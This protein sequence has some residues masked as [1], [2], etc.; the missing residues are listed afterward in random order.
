M[1]ILRRWRRERGAGTVDH[2][3]SDNDVDLRCAVLV[4]HDDASLHDND[5]QHHDDNDIDPN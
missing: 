4:D 5:E 1:W 2:G 3:G